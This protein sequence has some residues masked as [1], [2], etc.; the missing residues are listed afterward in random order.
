MTLLHLKNPEEKKKTIPLSFFL[1][2][3]LIQIK[4]TNK[5]KMDNNFQ[6]ILKR[7]STK[8]FFLTTNNILEE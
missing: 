6:I 2:E 1:C 7:K 4:N 3:Y 8:E 5:I